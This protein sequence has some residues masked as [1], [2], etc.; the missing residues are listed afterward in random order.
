[1]TD[2]LDKME[3]GTASPSYTNRQIFITK[4]LDELVNSLEDG[5]K[6]LVH[7]V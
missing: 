7:L 6:L 1:M 3:Y 2:H 4:T 5:Q